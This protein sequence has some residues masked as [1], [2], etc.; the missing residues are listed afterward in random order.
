[1]IHLLMH[2]QRIEFDLPDVPQVKDAK[3]R[4]A[5]QNGHVTQNRES[6]WI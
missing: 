6:F 5:R 2:S 1:M 4:G 3:S